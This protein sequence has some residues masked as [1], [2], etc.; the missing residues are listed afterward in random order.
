M[1]EALSE[2]AVWL[3][4]HPKEIVI[5]SCSHFE[6]MTDTDHMRLA[7]DIITLFGKKLCPHEVKIKLLFIRHCLHKL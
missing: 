4:A 5:I 3:D 6:G 2:L 1:Q 7:E